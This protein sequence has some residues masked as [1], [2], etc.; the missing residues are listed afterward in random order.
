MTR[1]T[2]CSPRPLGLVLGLLLVGASLPA[3]AQRQPQAAELNPKFKAMMKR[4]GPRAMRTVTEDGRPLGFL[5]DPFDLSHNQVTIK[6]GG[7]GLRHEVTEY[8]M[9]VDD[10]GRVPG[11]VTTADAPIPWRA[12]V[13]SRTCS[14]G[15]GIN[16]TGCPMTSSISARRASFSPRP[17]SRRATEPFHS[18]N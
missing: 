1:S 16:S 7:A 9:R 15:T 17:E 12:R 11:I 3:G 18:W 13:I 2:S 5:P 8:D 4:G 6:P 14:A 10:S